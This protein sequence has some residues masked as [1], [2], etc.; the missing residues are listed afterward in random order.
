M[1]SIVRARNWVDADALSLCL[2]QKQ[3]PRASERN[4]VSSRWQHK[5]GY[6]NDAMI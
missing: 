5:E 4:P 3:R 6:S 1:E 2:D